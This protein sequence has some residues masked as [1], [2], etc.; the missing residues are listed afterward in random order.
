MERIAGSMLRGHNSYSAIQ[1]KNKRPR[2]PTFP[3]SFSYEHSITLSLQGTVAGIVKSIYKR[4]L[5]LH[6]K[7][8]R[9]NYFWLD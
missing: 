3:Q 6:V 8:P 5:V 9:F 7:Y 4:N 2:N 1:T